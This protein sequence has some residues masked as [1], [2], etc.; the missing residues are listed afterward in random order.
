M[1]GLSY[2]TERKCQ[3]ILPS[4]VSVIFFFAYWLASTDKWGLYLLLFSTNSYF[5]SIPFKYNL[6]LG[7]TEVYQWDHTFRLHNEGREDGN[8][9]MKFTPK[10]TYRAKGRGEG[11]HLNVETQYELQLGVDCLLANR[12][13]GLITHLIC[14]PPPRWFLINAN[15]PVVY[16]MCGC[17]S[18]QLAT[19]CVCFSLKLC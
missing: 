10:N 2:F 19:N 4:S 14:P 11:W 1:S 18:E 9:M 16:C 6:L 8:F 3:I 7:N 13:G 17:S 12:L 15:T 5:Y